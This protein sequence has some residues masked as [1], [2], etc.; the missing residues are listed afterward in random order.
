MDGAAGE[1][2]GQRAVE[3]KGHLLA[4]REPADRQADLGV[5][6]GLAEARVRPQ[7]DPERRRPREPGGLVAHSEVEPSR[8]ALEEC[9]GAGNAGGL[10]KGD[11]GVHRPGGDRVPPRIGLA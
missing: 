8:V 9:R 3:V 4:A 5:I 1:D 11:I 10:V 6:G 7:L 2:V